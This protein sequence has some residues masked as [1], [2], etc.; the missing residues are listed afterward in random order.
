VHELD[1][2]APVVAEY[3]P[4]KH[5]TQAVERLAPVATRYEPA[6]HGEHD[7]SPVLDANVP[8]AQVGQAAEPTA[9][10]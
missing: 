9:A 7:A 2:V 5:A 4:A 8:A 1:V 3:F 10:D 6:G